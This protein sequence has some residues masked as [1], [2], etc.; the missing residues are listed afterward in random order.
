MG[1]IF[2]SITLALTLAIA[3]IFVIYGKERVYNKA[4][5]IIAYSRIYVC[6]KNFNEHFDTISR[7]DFIKLINRD[8]KS[9]EIGPY[10]APVLTGRNAKYFDVLSKEELIKKAISEKLSVD[11]I[12]NIDYLEPKGDLSIVKEKFDLVFSS[13]NIE[14]QVDLIKHLNQVADVMNEGAEFYLFIPD[15]RFCFDHFIAETPLSEIIAV[16]EMG[17]TTHSLQTVLSMRCET[18]HNDAVRHHGN[19]N[20]ER[21]GDNNINCYKDAL[22]EFKLA[23]GSYIDVHK[24]RFTPSSFNLIIEKLYDMR[25]INLKIKKLYGTQGN[26]HEFSVILYKPNK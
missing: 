26:S 8:L 17:L 2:I 10:Y 6:N 11:N 13:H 12:P 25:F 18:T 15:K 4:K 3:G 23:N 22:K 19:D 14:H 9:L 20:G 7:P 24:W 21:L 5:R 16:H 1:R